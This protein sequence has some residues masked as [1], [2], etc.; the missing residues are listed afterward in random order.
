LNREV[1]KVPRVGRKEL[2]LYRLY[3]SVQKRGGFN[4]VTQWKDLALDL[5]LPGSVTNAGYTL[6]TKYE[7]FILPFEKI[8]L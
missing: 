3:E 7:S 8:L 5:D 4:A 2:D 1:R 6:R